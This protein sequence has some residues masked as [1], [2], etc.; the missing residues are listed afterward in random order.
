MPDVPYSSFST[1]VK[2]DVAENIPS[3]ASHHSMTLDLPP[4]CIEFSPL[5]SDCFVVGTYYLEPE[6]GARHTI[7]TQ[8]DDQTRVPVQDRTGSLMLFALNNQKL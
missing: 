8:G 7:S 6:S 5:H 2:S 3:I 1:M 4:S